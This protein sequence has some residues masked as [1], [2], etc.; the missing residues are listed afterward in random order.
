MGEETAWKILGLEPHLQ[1]VALLLFGILVLAGVIVWLAK[2]WRTEV[3]GGADAYKDSLH[4]ATV[5]AKANDPQFERLHQEHQTLARNQRT[6]AK[7]GDGAD[8]EQP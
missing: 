6:L 2:A 4:M 8:I 1:V 7:G 3:K 5:L